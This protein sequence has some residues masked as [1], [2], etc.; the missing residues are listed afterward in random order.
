MKPPRSWFSLNG[1]EH[2]R[3]AKLMADANLVALQLAAATC[4]S[5]LTF[6]VFPRRHGQPDRL[7]ANLHETIDLAASA[8]RGATPRSLRTDP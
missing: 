6:T 1:S 2:H 3:L 4:S 8:A 5:V 7:G